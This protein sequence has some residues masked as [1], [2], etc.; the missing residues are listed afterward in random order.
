MLKKLE[1]LIR[2]NVYAYFWI[3]RIYFW[4]SYVFKVSHEPELEVLSRIP[5]RKGEI[6][7]VGACDGLSAV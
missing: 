7:D 3:R 4:Y 1:L 5:D 6:I 2:Q